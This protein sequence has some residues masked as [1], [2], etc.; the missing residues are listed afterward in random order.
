MKH[1][2]IILSHGHIEQLISLVKYFN[3]D[4]F[5]V[6]IHLDKK[7]KYDS[8][9]K[10]IL[11][12]M[13]NV[14]IYSKFKTNWGGHKLLECELFMLNE[15]LKNQAVNHFHFI[16]AQDVPTRNL[17]DFKTFFLKNEG[18]IFIKYKQYLQGEGQNET[19]E[20]LNLFRLN[21]L[22]N[23]R[24]KMGFFISKLCINIQEV[25]GVKRSTP[26]CFPA[27]F[28]GSAWFS[29][30]RESVKYL[31]D[32]TSIHPQF[33]RRLKFTFAAD[34]IYI[35]T[36]LLNSSYK[37]KIINN[38]LRYVNWQLKNGSIPAVLDKEDLFYILSAKNFFARKIDLSISSELLACL[39]K[40][41]QLEITKRD[42]ISPTGFWTTNC[43]ND[44]AYNRELSDTLCEILKLMKVQ[45]VVDVGCG[46][47]MYVI[48]LQKSGFQSIGVDGNPYLKEMTAILGDESQEI[49]MCA[50]VTQDL[51]FDVQ[52][53]AVISIDVG[54]YLPE[55]C[56][57]KYFHNLFR[58]TTK[59]ILIKWGPGDSFCNNSNRSLSP[60]MIN[61]EM[62]RRGACRN[63]FCSE[64]LNHI[65][66]ISDSLD[67]FLI[68]EKL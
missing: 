43:I 9:L 27:I 31:I 19:F 1:A 52:F 20:R 11:S 36:V 46:S 67:R 12:K 59:Y 58:L 48:D 22:F 33:Y 49:F 2:I 68:F 39:N 38:D 16:S 41:L 44:Y 25:I 4:D 34:E 53:D 57:S 21:D 40:N 10:E 50:D 3:D 30:S 28:G 14:F 29:L 32:Y 64:Y 37:E 17:S 7:N 47:G 51:F 23:E 56:V 61:L 15:A 54:I 55:E 5:V 63:D 35:N 8:I 62:M 45:S 65:L 24:S 26:S 42:E 6:L 18:L 66:K 60:D 13:N